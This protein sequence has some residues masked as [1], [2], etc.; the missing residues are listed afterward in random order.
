MHF[1]TALQKLLRNFD[2]YGSLSHNFMLTNLTWKL[3]LNLCVPVVK[4][5]TT[6]VIG[7]LEH[8]ALVLAQH[9]QLDYKPYSIV[10]LPS[11]HYLI[12]IH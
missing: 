10:R 12:T 6:G 9:F 3:L 11:V 5:R 2:Y 8:I 1:F 4:S 7:A